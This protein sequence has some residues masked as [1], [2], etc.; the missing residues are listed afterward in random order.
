MIDPLVAADPK[1]EGP[2]PLRRSVVFDR[3]TFKDGN[4][5][6]P[7]YG[8]LVRYDRLQKLQIE[9]GLRIR[10]KEPLE[11][12]ITFELEAGHGVTFVREGDRVK[13]R[14]L[15]NPEEAAIPGLVEARW[16]N[17]T[18]CTLVWNQS[19]ANQ[20]MKDRFQDIDRRKEIN[21]LRLFCQGG[22]TPVG[23]WEKNVTAVEGGLYVALLYSPQDAD[24]PPVAD[25]APPV[26][27]E[28]PEGGAPLK[29]EI[30]INDID[31]H[32]RPVYDLFRPYLESVLL[33][34]DLELEPA[35]RV[36]EGESVE[37]DLVLDIPDLRLQ[38]RDLRGEAEVM[39]FSSHGRP[40]QLQTTKNWPMEGR[41]RIRWLQE[42]GR[43]TCVTGNPD[44]TRCYCTTGQASS[45]LFT[46]AAAPVPGLGR[47]DLLRRLREHPAFRPGDDPEKFFA[48]VGI[49]PTVI[50]PPTCT[51]DGVCVP[52]GG[53]EGI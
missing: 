13:C 28:P 26:F 8:S 29:P 20:I 4:L 45:F 22:R 27:P 15:E 42:T 11:V 10:T 1:P 17:E 14:A 50:E 49:D 36:R 44:A 18:R 48:R 51:P 37:I 53:R 3:I 23:E 19:A 40:R 33:D 35:F 2:R 43:S 6:Q 30:R 32:G 47:E 34:P 52:R 41:C 7:R 31:A 38:W 39:P 9:P 24:G 21:T 46:A 5:W 16:D 25:A 12:A